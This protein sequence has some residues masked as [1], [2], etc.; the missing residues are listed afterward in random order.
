MQKYLGKERIC[1]SLINEKIKGKTL[2]IGAGEVLWIENELFLNNSNFISSDIEEKNLD[3]RNHTINKIKLDAVNLPF[4]DNELSQ[5]IILDVLEH[6]KDDLKVVKEMRRTLKKRGQ[7][8]ICV[9]NNNLLSF[10][11]PVKYAQ[12]ERHYSITHIKSLLEKNGF[13]IERVFC[14]GGFFELLD[15]YIHLIIKHTTGKMIWLDFLKKLKDKEYE[16]HKEKGN[17]IIIK[18][19]KLD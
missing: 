9:P 5:I 10:F 8:I 6:I 19:V 1:R 2:N 7:L 11:N 4:E 3:E 17:E 18:A 15:L 16:K 12:H 13:K 14:G